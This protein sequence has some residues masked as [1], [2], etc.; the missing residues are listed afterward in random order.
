MRW[1]MLALCIVALCCA[2]PVAAEGKPPQEYRILTS[3]TGDFPPITWLDYWN[4]AFIGFGGTYQDA[5]IMARD[6]AARGGWETATIT[7]ESPAP[8]VG[9][10]VWVVLIIHTAP[11]GGDAPPIAGPMNG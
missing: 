2:T 6:A 1:L 4:A 9:G 8:I 5:F 10:P 11:P 3:T 7:P